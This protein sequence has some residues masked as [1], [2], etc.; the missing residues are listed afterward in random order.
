M[1]LPKV[2]YNNPA[3]QRE[4][5]AFRGLNLSDQTRDGDL[6]QAENLSVRRYPFLAPRAGRSWEE[7]QSPTAIFEWDGKLIL[8]DGTTLYCGDQ[9]VGTV[10]EGEKQFAVVNT[11]LVIWPDMAYL[12][13][14]TMEFKD[15]TAKLTLPQGGMAT[16]TTNTLDIKSAYANQE[17]AFD[18][19][20][21]EGYDKYYNRMQTEEGYLI[22]R[23]SSVAWSESKGWTLSGAVEVG[24]YK[25]IHGD[26]PQGSRALAPGDVVMLR[27]SG[28]EGSYQLNTRTYQALNLEQEDGSWEADTIYGQYSADNDKGFYAKITAVSTAQVDREDG[29]L[30]YKVTVGYTVLSA[31]EEGPDLAKLY[32]A[33]DR[34]VIS[35]STLNS[36]PEGEHLTVKT[37]SGTVLTFEGTPFQAAT[38]SQGLTVQ[39]RMPS[40]DY[41]CESE[42]RLWGVSNQDRTIYASALGDPVNFYLYKGLSTDSYAVAVGSEGNWSAICRYG[43]SVLCWKEHTLHK[44]LGSYPAEYQVATYQYSGVAQDS[45]RS[46]RNLNEVLYYLG[47]DG[48]VYA[49]AGAAPRMVSQQFGGHRFTAGAAGTDGTRYYLSALEDGA[50]PSLLVYDTESGLWTRE[51]GTRAADFCLLEGKVVFLA[52][53]RVYT[54]DSGSSE[55]EVEWSATLA[56]FHETIQGKKRASKLFLRLEVPEGSWVEARLR[57]DGGRWATVGK[58]AGTGANV[59]VLPIA[60]NRCDKF[61]VQLRG[62]GGAA[63]LSMLR[64]YRVASER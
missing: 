22:R 24:V 9:A 8:V 28:I 3:A 38:E 49:Y 15:M 13:L 27:K 32:S 19:Y 53:K 5:V 41:I 62:R 16:F 50:D 14:S 52:G 7:H 21:L 30:A 44:V 23:Y 55:E 17:E 26:G 43:A 54:M 1:K 29:A 64:E 6:V 31:V 36:T 46:L 57:C 42:N 10:S 20:Y 58:L 18:V 51:D 35:G 45:H 59:K 4:T 61:Q 47:A 33:G 63:V 2:S 48:K 39:R 60:P 34:V 11:K 40:L 25:T 12:D 37:V 56:P